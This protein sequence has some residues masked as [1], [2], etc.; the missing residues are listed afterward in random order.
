[1]AEPSNTSQE[2][3]FTPSKRKPDLDTSE[4]RANLN[5]SDTCDLNK[6][7]K[8]YKVGLTSTSILDHF[9]KTPSKSTMSSTPEE[10]FEALMT[11]TET[12]VTEWQSIKEKLTGIDFEI[13]QIKDRQTRHDSHLN[14]L[15]AK[16]DE[17]VN[18]IFSV[19]KHT[20]TQ[21]AQQ[22][23]YSRN[24]N[25][26]I[27]GLA[28]K[29]DESI[30]E[31]EGM[32]IKFFDEKL[33]VQ[34]D[35]NDIDVIHRLGRPKQ[36]SDSLGSPTHSSTPKSKRSEDDRSDEEGATAMESETTSTGTAQS[37]TIIV[38]FV[39][40]KTKN[41]IIANRRKLKKKAGETNPVV[42]KEDLTKFHHQL[43]A[44]AKDVGEKAW[45]SEGK[46]FMKLKG[47]VTEIHEMSELL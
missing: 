46:I 5:S 40:R 17:N 45:S 28:E 31:L 9:A 26:R 27:Y 37:R 8:K 2:H 21:S 15:Q 43:L 12:M 11:R 36:T 32:V 44:K 33:G 41:M 6:G 18:T 13:S 4:I 34:V 22:E 35:K 10:R 14:G 24:Y 20:L 25:L 7:K 1:M 23:Q 3:Q 38:R 42:I 47:K 30:N 19:R 16:V 39:R 29:K